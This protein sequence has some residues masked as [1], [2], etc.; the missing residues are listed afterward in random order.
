LP[1]Q[2]VVVRLHP[3]SDAPPL[4][5][6]YSLCSAPGTVCYRLGIKKEVQGI[7]SNYI[8]GRLKVGDTVEVSAP[9]GDF[10][11]R[12][13]HR[14]VVLL[15]AGIGITPVLAM[16][17]S[18]ATESPQRMVWWFHGARSGTEYPF[19]EE[20]RT[21]LKRFP[22]GR[23]HVQYSKPGPT[24]REGVNFNARGRLEPAVLE[25]LGV[26]K[27]SAFY[28]CGPNAFMQDFVAG[29][30]AWGVRREQVFTETFGAGGSITPG[31]VHAPLR[32]PHAPIGKFDKG[33]RVSFARSGLDV[34]WDPALN[35]LLELAE[36]C[37]VPVRWACRTGVCHTCETG[38]IA[39]T[40][41][42]NPDPLEPP[43]NGNLLICCSRPQGDVVIDL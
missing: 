21:L 40:V 38:L 13:D 25:R 6:S 42:Y 20:T 19:A 3:R 9:R 10:V 23:S 32:S 2:F 24:D 41:N 16:L 8:A 29:L 12:A 43:G 1:G 36:A 4:L 35:S 27:E 34:S 18:L 30:A 22:N 31:I 28:L 33:P 14:S 39:G 5:R 26:S 15:S 37:G 7:A 11:L 17:H